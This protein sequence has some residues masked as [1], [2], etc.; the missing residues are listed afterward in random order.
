MRMRLAVSALVRAMQSECARCK[1]H[2]HVNAQCAAVSAL[3]PLMGAMHALLR[4]ERKASSAELRA[5]FRNAPIPEQYDRMATQLIWNEKRQITS[6]LQNYS[7]LRKT[8]KR[9]SE[10]G[11]RGYPKRNAFLPNTYRLRSA[12]SIIR[13]F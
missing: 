8:V 5:L 2:V 10:Y 1:V 11:S 4:Q 7:S 12:G 9:T 6:T 3:C 13:V